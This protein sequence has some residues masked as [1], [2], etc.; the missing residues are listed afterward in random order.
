MAGLGGAVGQACELLVGLA[1]T[2]V[3]V[4]GDEG[5]PPK[6]FIGKMG[7]LDG[8]MYVDSVV[9]VAR[10]TIVTRSSRLHLHFLRN[11]IVLKS[12]EV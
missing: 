9:M 6:W 3:C 1:P 4:V 5:E 11:M 2:D 10:K 12:I 8:G 7:V